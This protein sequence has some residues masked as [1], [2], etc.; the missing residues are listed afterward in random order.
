MGR[1]DGRGVMIQSNG[2]LFEGRWKAGDR[3]YGRVINKNGD[4]YHGQWQNGK[5]NGRGKYRSFC[6]MT[7]VEGEWMNDLLEGD[8]ILKKTNSFKYRG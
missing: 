8:A 4:T 2:S 6:G 5:R 7:E 1:P 3:V